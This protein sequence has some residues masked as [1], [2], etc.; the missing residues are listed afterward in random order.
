MEALDA[1]DPDLLV[2]FASPHF[3]AAF[4]DMTYAL[5]NLLDP[6]VLIGMTVVA[7]V[8]I[9]Q[10]V[11]D[12]PALSV[13]G[14]R[15]PDAG[16]TPVH[17]DVAG[18][19]DR[20]AVVGGPDRSNEPTDASLL[21]LADPFSFP[22]ES[23]LRRLEDDSPRLTVIGGMASAARGPG[24]NRLVLDD[25]V[26][27][28]G[29]VGVVVDGTEVRTVVSQGCR[30]VGRPY[31][32]TKSRGN[33]VE[34]LASRPA[35]AR[36]TELAQSVS[37]EE[38]ALLQAGLHLGIVVD[39]HRVEFGAGDFLVRTVLGSEATTGAIVT[40]E[41]I[42]VGRTVQFHARDAEAA[43]EEL[44]ALLAHEHAAAALLF[45]DNG[46]GQG[47]FGT[48]DHDAGVVAELLGRV[49]LAGGF[50][51]G[52]LGPVGGRNHLHGFTASLALFS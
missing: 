32:V 28:R 40:G 24:G 46:R 50:C 16:L 6:G 39:E 43:D 44:R 4:D 33:V 19:P 26:V 11:E 38:R 52:E 30:P 8:G 49:P 34:E 45:T 2:C 36:L 13:F 27:D 51:A 12:G 7:V 3:V 48:P 17:L 37:E 31:V 42:P 41:E 23:A 22:V 18:A 14:A 1:E 10:E 20:D 15:L 47:L 25:T 9:E 29:A 5:R 35:L 21:L